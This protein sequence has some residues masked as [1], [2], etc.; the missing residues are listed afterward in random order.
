MLPKWLRQDV[1][2]KVMRKEVAMTGRAMRRER[3]IADGW[4]TKGMLKRDGPIFQC[5][6]RW[7][8]IQKGAQSWQRGEK[9][10]DN[11]LSNFKVDKIEG[12]ALSIGSQQ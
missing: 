3:C 1:L 7:L 4:S 10:G 11:L 9:L 12:I 8:G 6:T 5:C 2:S